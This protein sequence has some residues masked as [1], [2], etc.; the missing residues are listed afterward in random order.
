M[1]V[2][3][4]IS[5]MTCS[6]S[7]SS[8]LFSSHAVLRSLSRSDLWVDF[9]SPLT[10]HSEWAF[11]QC[12]TGSKTLLLRVWKRKHHETRLDMLEAFPQAVYLKK[13]LF[14]WGT[15]YPD[16]SVPLCV[17]Q[18][19]WAI[20]ARHHRSCKAA[21]PKDTLPK[22]E[23]ITKVRTELQKALHRNTWLSLANS[24]TSATTATLQPR[25]Q[26]P[27]VQESHYISLAP[28]LDWN[29]ICSLV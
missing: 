3:K 10:P 20:S 25:L 16:D 1:L 7:A 12:G 4:V 24:H 17:P 21:Q 18:I 29:S 28:W 23:V 11:G 8:G 2:P 9:P 27:E 6:S 26:D 19:C 14:S 13:P 5:D 22:A 15:D